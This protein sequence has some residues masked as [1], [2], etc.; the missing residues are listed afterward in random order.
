MTIIAP[1]HEEAAL[2]YL[3]ERAV[4]MEVWE[5]DALCKEIGNRLFYPEQIEGTPTMESPSPALTACGMCPVMAECRAYALANDERL[6][7]W[8]G[9]TLEARKRALAT[10]ALTREALMDALNGVEPSLFKKKA[11][12]EAPADAQDPENGELKAA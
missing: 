9:M 8:G 10:P 12:V 11:K 5:P 4:R 7:V 3:A 6:G 2:R 1:E